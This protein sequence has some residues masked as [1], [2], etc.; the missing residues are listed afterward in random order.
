MGPSESRPSALRQLTFEAGLAITPAVSPDGKLL[1]YA[2]DRSGEGQ[3]DI[4]FKQLAGGEAV[5]L[6]T[7][8]D[9]KVNPQFSPE[10]TRIYFLGGRS[11]IYEV[12]T[13]GGAS[14]MVVEAAGPFS[15]SSRGDIAFH[16]LG[17][18]NLPGPMFVLAVGTSGVETWHPEC[19]SAGAP[20]W[21]P[22][23]TRIAFAGLCGRTPPAGVASD[24][25]ILTAPLGGGATERV[26]TVTVQLNAPRLAWIRLVAVQRSC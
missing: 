18:G 2:S 4:W 25:E 22:D 14:R 20:I 6:T 19:S 24:H 13:L 17:T 1:A 11:A 26:G 12:P 15:V 9:S 16:R 3:L 5:R 23:G 7:G 10:G 21:S 8:P